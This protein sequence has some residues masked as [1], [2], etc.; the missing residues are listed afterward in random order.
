MDD[1]ENSSE[2]RSGR[3]GTQAKARKIQQ[4]QNRKSSQAGRHVRNGAGAQA[5]KPPTKQEVQGALHGLQL[6]KPQLDRLIDICKKGKE[7][8]TN[9]GGRVKT[10]IDK[11]RGL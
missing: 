5:R 10:A 7:K 3:D 6:E 4:I 11:M 2:S 8:Q 1:V 9:I